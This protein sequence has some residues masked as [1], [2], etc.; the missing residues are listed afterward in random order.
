MNLPDVLTNR[1]IRYP[2]AVAMRLR[3]VR[4]RLLGAQ[5]GRDCRIRR[6]EVPTSPSDIVIRD[7]VAVDDHVVLLTRRFN[8]LAAFLFLAAIIK[9]CRPR[10]SKA[11]AFDQ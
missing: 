1:I 8:Y 10:R 5:I 11:A 3:I 4:L 6:I 2:G 7:G 9:A